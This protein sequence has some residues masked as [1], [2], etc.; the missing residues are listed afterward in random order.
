MQKTM[1]VLKVI[2]LVVMLSVIIG[3]N[4]SPLIQRWLRPIFALGGM[5]MFSAAVIYQGRFTHRQNRPS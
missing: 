5:A 2:G 3:V 1:K 4:G